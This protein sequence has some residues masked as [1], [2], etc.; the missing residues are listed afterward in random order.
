MWSTHIPRRA[1]LTAVAAFSGMASATSNHSPNIVF[2]YA[3]DLGYGDLGCYGSKIPTPNIGRMA[4]EGVRL[5]QFYSASPVCS[6]FT[7][8]TANG[9]LP[10]P[11]RRTEGAVPFRHQGPS[12]LRNHNRPDAEGSGLQETC[13]SVSGILAVDRSSFPQTVVLT[14]SLGFPIAMTCTRGL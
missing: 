5:R 14:N 13:A 7:G 11:G 8:S 10:D 3:D 12:R 9:A 4:S 6:P 2:I 1:F